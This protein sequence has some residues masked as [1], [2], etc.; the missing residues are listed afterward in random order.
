[1]YINIL[2]KKCLCYI[3]YESIVNDYLHVFDLLIMYEKIII[4]VNEPETNIYRNKFVYFIYELTRLCEKS[5]YYAPY[6]VT[7][8]IPPEYKLV[9]IY[10]FA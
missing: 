8:N 9:Y 6:P 2:V 3:F 1:M 4:K 5:H 10:V 7:L